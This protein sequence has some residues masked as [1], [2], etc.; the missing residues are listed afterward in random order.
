MP[1]QSPTLAPLD[2]VLGTLLETWG[3]R[4]RFEMNREQRL[5]LLSNPPD[6]EVGAKELPDGRIH[7]V[8]Q[9]SPDETAEEFCS[10]DRA[11]RLIDAL[12]AREKLG[13]VTLTPVA[14][15]QAAKPAT[16][17]RKSGWLAWLFVRK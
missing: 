14:G 17:H 11:V 2:Q 7:V 8:F 5:L 3:Q 10:V 15:T 12:M 6:I 9:S 16:S 1:P 13:P 4:Y